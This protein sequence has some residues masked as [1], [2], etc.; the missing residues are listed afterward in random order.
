[1]Y[2]PGSGGL[3]YY[4]KVEVY[5]PRSGKLLVLYTRI[6]LS[7]GRVVCRAGTTSDGDQFEGIRS[8]KRASINMLS[9]VRLLVCCCWYC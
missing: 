8:L 9:F 1:M 6:S 5:D 4:L 3:Q 7:V 2:D